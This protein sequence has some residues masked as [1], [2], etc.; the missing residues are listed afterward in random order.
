MVIIEARIG[1]SKC[2]YA[3]REEVLGVNFFIIVLKLSMS[4][5]LL[6]DT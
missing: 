2:N 6:R 4:Q 5:Y 3:L 1:I